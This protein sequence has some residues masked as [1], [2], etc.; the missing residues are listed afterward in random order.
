M[1]CPQDLIGQKVWLSPPSSESDAPWWELGEDSQKRIQAE[2]TQPTSPPWFF[3]RYLGNPPSS[4]G[5]GQ[6][7]T[8]YEAQQAVLLNPV[9]EVEEEE[10]EWDLELDDLDVYQDQLNFR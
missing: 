6:W 3:A 2:I 8:L 4:L 5:S 7:M 9:L 10:Q 1:L